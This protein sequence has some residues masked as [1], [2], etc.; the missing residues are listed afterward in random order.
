M[1]YRF[2]VSTS[3]FQLWK[4]EVQVQDNQV[5]YVDLMEELIKANMKIITLSRTQ[6]ELWRKVAAAGFLLKASISIDIAVS[7]TK[8]FFHDCDYSRIDFYWYGYQLS[9]SR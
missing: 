5:F 4:F 2:F 3:N 9:F 7:L 6:G 8:T 1:L